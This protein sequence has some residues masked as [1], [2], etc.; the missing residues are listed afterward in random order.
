MDF[1]PD[2]YCTIYGLKFDGAINL[3][4]ESMFHKEVFDSNTKIT[5]MMLDLR[6]K[7]ECERDR[8]S[9]LS[10]KLALLYVIYCVFFI[11]EKFLKTIDL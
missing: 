2:E 8:D 7:E 5:F 3:P 10:F 1:G 11:R 9:E 4:N 6:F